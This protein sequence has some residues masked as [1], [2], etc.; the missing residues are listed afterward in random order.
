M[1][2]TATDDYLANGFN[3]RLGFGERPALI[4]IDFVDAY[5]KPE[6][7]LYA[8]VEDALAS[9]TRVLHAARAAGIPIIYTVVEQDEGVAGGGIFARKVKGLATLAT[10]SPLGAIAAPLAPQPGESILSKK[11]ASS[12]FGTSLATDLTVLGRDSVILV[13]LSTSGCV[14]ATAVDA[15]QHG[16]IPLVVREAVGDR[17]PEPHDA[18]LFDLDAKYADVVSES[19]TLD[20]LTAL[21]PPTDRSAH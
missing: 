10:G 15:M 12:F 5:L 3:Q 17:R 13:G 14:R 18:A 9:S 2:D 8:G 21:T 1:T 11:Y 6:S 7:P 4:V 20:H 19:E 16:F